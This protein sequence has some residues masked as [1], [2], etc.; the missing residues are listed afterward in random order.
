M[1]F[2]GCCCDYS[3]CLTQTLHQP[4]AERLTSGLTK[5]P[6]GYRAP[7]SFYSLHRVLKCC[8]WNIPSAK[9]PRF[10]LNQM[11][12]CLNYTFHPRKFLPVLVHSLKLQSTQIPRCTTATPKRQPGRCKASGCSRAQ[13]GTFLHGLIIQF[14]QQTYAILVYA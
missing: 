11:R 1:T 9:L 3:L 10:M 13:G 4:A 8:S 2:C 14:H 5:L 12:Y 6:N 7:L